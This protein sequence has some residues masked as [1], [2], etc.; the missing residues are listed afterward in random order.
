M[1]R[2][3]GVLIR[4]LRRSPSFVNPKNVAVIAE[5]IIESPKRI[6][7]KLSSLSARR[8]A[9]LT[10]RALLFMS[11]TSGVCPNEKWINLAY[12]SVMVFFIGE[13][14]T[15]FAILPWLS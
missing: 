12:K 5:K 6:F 15:I 1:I 11:F 14:F 13:Y 7:K 10:F 2:P 8:Y 9:G 4:K 3:Q